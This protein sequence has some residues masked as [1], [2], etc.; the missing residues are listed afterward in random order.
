MKKKQYEINEQDLRNI[1]HEK[2][3]EINYSFNIRKSK[4]DSAI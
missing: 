4:I 3:Q 2:L 1:Y